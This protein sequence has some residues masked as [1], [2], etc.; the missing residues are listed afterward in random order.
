M[1]WV[2]RE[3]KTEKLVNEL[4]AGTKI[5]AL[6]RLPEDDWAFI[7]EIVVI[8]AVYLQGESIGL[9]FQIG[10]RQ[11]SISFHN[12]SNELFLS[13]GLDAGKWL[14]R[15]YNYYKQYK[16]GDALEDTDEKDEN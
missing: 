6:V 14:K 2:R 9:T 3:N 12:V 1:N 13:V 5:W 8:E 15:Q 10:E 11:H 4:T 16:S 7:R